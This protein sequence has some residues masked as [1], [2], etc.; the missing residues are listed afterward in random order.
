[1]NTDQN[2]LAEPVARVQRR[3]HCAADEPAPAGSH[4]GRDRERERKAADRIAD[5]ER[6]R[7]RNAADRPVGAE[8]CDLAERQVDPS[9]QPVDQR[10]GGGEQRI[11]RR[12]R[13]RIDQLLQGISRRG[14][15]SG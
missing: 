1:L 11:D 12:E 14:G 8:H 2:G 6:G 9:G 4:R 15:Q 7:R 5:A 3:H 10:I 13:E